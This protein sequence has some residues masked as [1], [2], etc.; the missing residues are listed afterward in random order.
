MKENESQRVLQNSTVDGVEQRAMFWEDSDQK[1]L[2]SHP[3][4]TGMGDGGNNN[5]SL[6]ELL[7]AFEA[8]ENSSPV[9][10]SHEKNLPSRER[11]DVDEIQVA[12]PSTTLSECDGDMC[13]AIDQAFLALDLSKELQREKRSLLE[14]EQA[15]DASKNTVS[16]S[17]NAANTEALKAKMKEVKALERKLTK[18]VREAKALRKKNDVVSYTMDMDADDE[19]K[20][21]ENM[22]FETMALDEKHRKETEAYRKEKDGLKATLEMYPSTDHS[23]GEAKL[24][25]KRD[26][27]NAL[28]ENLGTK[29]MELRALRT[30]RLQ[31]SS[32]ARKKGDIVVTKAQSLTK[33]TQKSERF[34]IW[35]LNTVSLRTKNSV[36]LSVEA[37]LSDS[38]V[39]D[40][41]AKDRT[42]KAAEIETKTGVNSDND[43]AIA[44][45]TELTDS[46]NSTANSDT[47]DLDTRAKSDANAVVDH[48]TITNEDDEVLTL[49]SQKL[50]LKDWKKAHKIDFIETSPSKSPAIITAASDLNGEASIKGDSHL[51]KSTIPNPTD[52]ETLEK[53]QPPA[54]VLIQDDLTEK[55]QAD[56]ELIHTSVT[57]EVK[58]QILN[59]KD[60]DPNPSEPNSH[61]T[62]EQCGIPEVTNANEEP[63]C[64][65]QPVADMSDKEEE[66]SP[67]SPPPKLPSAEEEEA[68]SGADLYKQFAQDAKSHGRAANVEHEEEEEEEEEVEEETVVEEEETVVEEEKETSEAGVTDSNSV[69]ENFD[70]PEVVAVDG[71]ASPDLFANVV[72]TVDVSKKVVKAAP[73]GP[74][75]TAAR[76][77]E[78][79]EAEEER[80]KEKMK[81]NRKDAK[82]SRMKIKQNEDTDA[83]LTLRAAE[84]HLANMS[85]DNPGHAEMTAFVESLSA[86]EETLDKRETEQ[87][88]RAKELDRREEELRK[89]LEDM[90]PESVEIR[91]ETRVRVRVRS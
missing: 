19:L 80:R 39:I 10:S 63:A 76:Y 54:F 67:V 34:H 11:S 7:I 24:E 91:G 43:V 75:Q 31:K 86:R 82:A 70:I 85:E 59:R 25:A 1:S 90:R 14:D 2:S 66:P 78:L 12:D 44:D 64:S 58:S 55:V 61:N 22:S 21:L 26:E 69:P 83:L 89:Q 47:L 53:A 46:K 41:E 3:C 29:I 79:K 77:V 49:D 16:T 33:S 5:E 8:K 81:K 17:T 88:M 57:Q 73:E 51:E 37:P 28:E 36:S 13:C 65:I 56:T 32:V 84:E 72:A 23:A 6:N 9:I 40:I 45:C 60:A 4:E 27:V 71:T 30:S 87:E 42:L 52:D 68:A 15:L 50:F 38:L 48:T 35:R 62:D 74:A 18:N 20:T